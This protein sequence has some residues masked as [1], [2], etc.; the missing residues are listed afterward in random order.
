MTKNWKERVN[1][2]EREG[3]Q[4]Y[5]P[6]LNYQVFFLDQRFLFRKAPAVGGL[7]QAGNDE[8]KIHSEMGIGRRA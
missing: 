7:V 8:F 6:F 5:F 3:Q 4:I 1:D 2:F